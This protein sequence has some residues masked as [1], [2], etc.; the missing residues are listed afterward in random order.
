[1][2]IDDSDG[3][4]GS[5]EVIVK[6]VKSY[7]RSI[8][9][10]YLDS[11]CQAPNKVCTAGPPGQKGIRGPP[12]KPGRKGMNGFEGP[13]GIMG[14]PG[15][16]GPRGFMRD[17]GAP[18]FK[19]EKGK[20]SQGFRQFRKVADIF[21]KAPDMTYLWR[22]K[23]RFERFKRELPRGVWGQNTHKCCFERFWKPSISFPGKA[24]V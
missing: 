22:R 9:K 24:G 20:H 2:E 18:G 7:V 4:K 10:G 8:V 11:I 13:K 6:Y 14:P 17:S 12:G 15:S 5:S 21:V 23:A 1:M 16:P 19:G 3:R